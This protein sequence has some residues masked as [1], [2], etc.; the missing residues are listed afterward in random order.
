MP[1]ASAS[2]SPPDEVVPADVQEHLVAPMAEEQSA[3][4]LWAELERVRHEHA[5]AVAEAQH[6]REQ[7]AARAEHIADL[8]RALKALML[9][10]E[11]PVLGQPSVP[12]QV[13]PEGGSAGSLK[14]EATGGDRRRWWRR[15]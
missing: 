2:P 7:L 3:A 5:L 10:P 15:G 12:G 11:R 8:Q 4:A 13:Q 6:L 14:E 1:Q 9:A